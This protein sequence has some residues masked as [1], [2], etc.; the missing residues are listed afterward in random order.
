MH[1]IHITINPNNPEGPVLV[2]GVYSMGP[3]ENDISPRAT[4][5]QVS[6]PW[7]D[8]A[9]LSTST[10]TGDAAA[11]AQDRE[12]DQSS[13]SAGVVGSITGRVVRLTVRYDLE[14]GEEENSPTFMMLRVSINEQQVS[15][16]LLVFLGC[17]VLFCFCFVLS[18]CLLVYLFVCLF[19]DLFCFVC[20]PEMLDLFLLPGSQLD[21]LSSEA[22]LC[23]QHTL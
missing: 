16:R 5:A 1:M 12:A 14:G 10:T 21:A 22:C 20:D 19:I 8:I 4:R 13:T 2:L 3:R 17:F 23:Q 11:A 15:V 6:I 9:P 18:A 7:R